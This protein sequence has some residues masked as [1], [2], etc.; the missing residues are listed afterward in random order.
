VFSQAASLSGRSAYNG[1][2]AQFGCFLLF[3]GV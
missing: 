1:G 3:H 2:F